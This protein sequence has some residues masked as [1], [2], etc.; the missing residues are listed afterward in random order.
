M[1]IGKQFFQPRN[2]CHVHDGNMATLSG[3]VK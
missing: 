1:I 2:W 3:L